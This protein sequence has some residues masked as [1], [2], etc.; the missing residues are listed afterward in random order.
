VLSATYTRDGS[1][2]NLKWEDGAT[3]TG[4]LDGNKFTTDNE[5][6]TFVYQK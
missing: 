5:G 1:T 3:T 6:M 2:L 4:S